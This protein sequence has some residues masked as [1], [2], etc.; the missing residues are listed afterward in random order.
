AMTAATPSPLVPKLRFPEC[1]DDE[2]WDAKSLD[3][4]CERITETVGDTKLTPVSISS[5]KGFVPQVEKFGRDIPGEQYSKYIWI[6]RGDFAYNRGNSKRFP[7]GCVYPLVELDEAA[8]SNAFYCFRLNPDCEPA[9]F[10]GLFE[11]NAHGHQLIKFITSSARNTGLLNIRADDFFGI[12]IPIPKTLPE[13][14][15]IADCLGSLDALIAGHGRKLK[16]LREH[17][18]GLMQQL[19]P[20]EGETQ[21]RLRFP[22]FRSTNQLEEKKLDDL[23]KRGTGHTPSKSKPEYYNGEIKWVSL[24]DS[25]RLDS[26]LIVDTSKTISDQGISNSS[27]TLHPTGSVILSR[28]AGVGKSAVLGC[29]MAVSQH[30]IAWFCDEL[31]LYNWFLYH[32]L[33]VSKR[34]FEDIATGS[35]IKTIGLPFFKEMRIV[36]PSLAEQR[37]IA[38][39]LSS[40]DALIAAHAQKIDALKQHKQGL[41]QQ[42]FPVPEGG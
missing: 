37:S 20:Q 21:P 9:F 11:K 30:F 4:L 14:K 18:K 32:F 3:D 2:A 36:V 15:K 31:Q 13:Q 17:K 22:E 5:G 10:C 35:T 29:P 19:F 12:T 38:D 39:C 6:R 41:M 25:W 27:A 23:A 26:G 33:Q 7:Q 8:A 42:L 28:D 1:A 16:A 34:T 24:A 40:L